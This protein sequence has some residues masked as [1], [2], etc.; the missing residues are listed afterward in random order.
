LFFFPFID[1]LVED[2]VVHPDRELHGLPRRWWR[3][4]RER[5]PPGPGG[6]ALELPG[7]RVRRVVVLLVVQHHR[8]HPSRGHG[9]RF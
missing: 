9:G 5:L 6:G 3:C 8:A 4:V 1:L 2:G 7:L